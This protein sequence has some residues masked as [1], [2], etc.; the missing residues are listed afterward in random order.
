MKFILS[1]I[2]PLN[3]NIFAKINIKIYYLEYLFYYNIIYI[4]IKIKDFF[5][6][7]NEIR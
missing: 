3:H 7:K 5:I 6:E 1:M 4:E 2:S